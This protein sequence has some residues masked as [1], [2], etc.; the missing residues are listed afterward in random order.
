MSIQLKD[1]PFRSLL[2]E[3][4]FNSLEEVY[5]ANALDPAMLSST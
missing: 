5:R 2:G 1:F 4:S 3:I